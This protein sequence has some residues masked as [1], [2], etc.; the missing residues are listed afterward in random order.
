MNEHIAECSWFKVY[1]VAEGL[2]A[3][4]ANAD[5]G[6]ARHFADRLNQFFRENGVG[7][8]MEESLIA[9]RGSEVFADATKEAVAAL[10]DTG[11][12]RAA[13]EIHEALRDI[14]RRPEPDVTG[15]IQHVVAAL[16]SAAR[17][18]TGQ[19]NPHSWPACPPSRPARP[20]RYG[21]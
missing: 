19:P 14:S 4:L 9:F 8:E 11:R 2:H 7:W 20:S 17:D 1:D 18:V 5:P 12:Q 6:R 15:A 10:T 3:A 16:E 13:N 21:C